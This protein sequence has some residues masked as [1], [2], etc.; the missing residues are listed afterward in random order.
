MSEKHRHEPIR[1]TAA[2][3]DDQWASRI[4]CCLRDTRHD[5]STNAAG[6]ILIKHLHTG[7]IYNLLLP[8]GAIAFTN[9]DEADKAVDSLKYDL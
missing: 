2:D 7:E 8:H 6:Q 3:L 1:I 4:R 9:R 5:L